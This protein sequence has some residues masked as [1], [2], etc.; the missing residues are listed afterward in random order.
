MSSQPVGS[1]T[2]AREGEAPAEPAACAGYI[3]EV[4]LPEIIVVVGDHAG[5]D[6][7]P[8]IIELE[9]LPQMVPPDGVVGGVDGAVAVVVAGDA[10]G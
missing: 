6:A 9:G 4:R 1:G 5:R 3:A 7:G 10:G 8:F 2:A